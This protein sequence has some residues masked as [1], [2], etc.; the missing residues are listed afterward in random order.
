MLQ[1]DRIQDLVTQAVAEQLHVLAR[2]LIAIR[3]ERAEYRPA[4]AVRLQ[5]LPG[6]YQGDVCS[7]I[8]LRAGSCTETWLKSMTR[9]R[10]PPS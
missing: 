10:A 6:E 4:R 8:N 2:G 7:D 1:P 3:V 9:S 5:A